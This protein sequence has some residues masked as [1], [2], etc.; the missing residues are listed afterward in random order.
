MAEWKSEHVPSPGILHTAAAGDHGVAWAFGILVQEM[1]E[2]GTLVF[3]RGRQQWEQVEAPQIGRVNR[4]LAVS[5]SDVW[6]VGDGWSLHWDGQQ[7]RK[8]PATIIGGGEPQLFGLAQ[9]GADDVWTAGYAPLREDRRARG[10]VQHW[11]GSAWTDLP[12]PAVAAAWSLAGIAGTSPVDLWA[13]GGV[14]EVQGEALA[15]HWDGQEWE[16]VPVPGVVGRSIHLFDIA[17][18]QNG[19][20]WAAGYSQDSG[21][22]RTRQPFTVHWDGR[23]WSPGEIPEGPGQITQLATDGKQ[24]WGLGYTPA[25]LPYVTIL[26]A[27][28]WHLVPGPAGPPDATRT[29]L[30]GGAIL[31]D[32]SLLAIGAS[33][34]PHNSTRPLAAVLANCP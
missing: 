6:A 21:N 30:H 28:S 10:T 22:I 16:R 32:G 5:G 34:M 12:V 33:S 26:Q 25:G 14:H 27:T 7:W 18:L 17:V 13:V 31:A 15:L 3:R 1:G 20:T 11:D 2:F 9:F 24:V 4:A 23:A 29:F 19:D 8:V